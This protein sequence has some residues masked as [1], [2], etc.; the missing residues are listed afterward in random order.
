MIL[1]QPLVE[2]AKTEVSVALNNLAAAE[3]ASWKIPLVL[4]H[5]TSASGLK[6]I[7][8]SGTLWA[9]DVLH[10]NDSSE[11]S[12]AVEL[13]RRIFVGEAEKHTGWTK[14]LL[15]TIIPTLIEKLP[16]VS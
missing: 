14:P 13:I 5:Y 16:M 6:G 15:S 9:T 12:Y 4:Y 7:V 1:D 11:I 2:T 3:P 8:E 10:L